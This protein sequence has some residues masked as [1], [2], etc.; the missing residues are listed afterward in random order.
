MNPQFWWYLTRSSGIIAWLMLTA[1]V[2][3]GILVSTKA[4]PNQRR[5]VWL[6]A[7]H[8]WLAGLMLCFLAIHLVAL[9]AD[10]YVSFDLA[11]LTVP[12]VSDW[13]PGAVAL[14]V[15]AMWLLVA[16]QLTSLAMRRLPRRFW[17][18]VHLT[19]YVAFWLTSLHGAYAGT[20][21]TSRMYQAAAVASILA[22]AWA[23][24]YRLANRRSV[25]RAGRGAAPPANRPAA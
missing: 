22:V 5:P 20:D 1:S 15:V 12:Y 25:R 21:T 23:L 18:V 16:V 3:W 6:L 2:I 10:S 9:V 7:V 11:D 19:S 8:R 14:G 17:R 13:K 4:F 24:M